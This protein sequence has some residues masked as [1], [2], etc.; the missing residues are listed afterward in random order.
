MTSVVEQTGVH[1][2]EHRLRQRLEAAFSEAIR[3]LFADVV[4]ALP[5]VFLRGLYLLTSLAARNAEEAAHGVCLPTGGS[6]DLGQN[7]RVTRSL[8]HECNR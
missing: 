5:C 6:H 4:R 8:N 2:R 1:T 7:E 3:W